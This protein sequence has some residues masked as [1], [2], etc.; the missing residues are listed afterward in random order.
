[1]SD[2]GWFDRSIH[3]DTYLKF[4]SVFRSFRIFWNFLKTLA[5]FLKKA[6]SFPVVYRV[7]DGCGS[8]LHERWVGEARGPGRAGGGNRSVHDFAGQPEKFSQLQL[9]VSNNRHHD[10]LRMHVVAVFA[11]CSASIVYGCPIGEHMEERE[12]YERTKKSK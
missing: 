6:G 8:C 11:T 7:F 5:F 10:Q 4:T 9:T 2:C 3:G 1:M 12:Q